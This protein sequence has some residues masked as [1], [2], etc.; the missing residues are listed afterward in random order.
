M[1]AAISAVLFQIAINVHV[2]SRFNCRCEVLLHLRMAATS[3]VLNVRICHEWIAE[4]CPT[5]QHGFALTILCN[6]TTTEC[7]HFPTSTLLVLCTSPS[8]I[9]IV[10][11]LKLILVVV[12]LLVIVIVIVVV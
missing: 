11:V 2:G 8:L 5:V 7:V 6:T 1:G 10:M 9:I 4:S 3:R 12:V